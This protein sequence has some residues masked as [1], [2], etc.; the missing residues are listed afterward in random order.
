MVSPPFAVDAL[1]VIVAWLAAVE[2]VTFDGV[3]ARVRGL[4]VTVALAGEEPIAVSAMAVK[5]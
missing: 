2:T 1:Q 4:P 5:E 3:L